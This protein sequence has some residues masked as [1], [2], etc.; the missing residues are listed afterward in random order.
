MN[1]KD[2]N[3]IS[4]AKISENATIKVRTMIPEKSNDGNS[5][6]EYLLFRINESAKY[7]V[8]YEKI[9]IQR[10]AK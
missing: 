3:S 6:I 8:I 1:D 9:K 5:M 2:S 4:T 10:R 7:K